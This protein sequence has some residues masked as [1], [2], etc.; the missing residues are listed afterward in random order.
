VNKTHW[1]WL[2]AGVVTVAV[3]ASRKR[4]SD[5]EHGATVTDD[6]E[7]LARVITSEADRYSL[8]ERTAIAWTV[9]NRAHKR[10]VSIARLVCYPECGECCTGR[11]F[12][13][14][15][16]ATAENRDLARAVLAAPSSEDPT[17]GALA[18]FEPAVQD[19]LVAEHRRGYRFN[20][21]QTRAKW[22]R[23]GQRQL[24]TVGKFEFWA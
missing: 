3:I 22:L 6:T 12:S 15:R 4:N 20:A 10:G 9:R 17:N 24:N 1:V 7:A 5:G 18:F 13:S 19:R 14:A 23:E 21:E 8:L 11:P 2:G 16:P